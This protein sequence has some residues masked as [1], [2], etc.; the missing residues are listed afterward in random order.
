MEGLYY[1]YQFF[2]VLFYTADANKKS[3]R[4]ETK[5]KSGDK[6]IRFCSDFLLNI[7][8]IKTNNIEYIIIKPLNVSYYDDYTLVYNYTIVCIIVC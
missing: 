6:K 7:I 8:I 4:I 3:I 5:D 1:N 2:V